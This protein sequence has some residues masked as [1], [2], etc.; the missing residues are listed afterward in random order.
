MK[1]ADFLPNVLTARGAPMGRHSYGIAENCEP[2]SVRLFR[3][4]LDSGGYDRGGAY[5]G[6]GEPLYMAT[7]GGEYRAFTRAASR[8]Y[9]MA[10]LD[11]APER[12]RVLPRLPG[13]RYQI[14][15]EYI[16]KDSC[17]WVFRVFEVSKNPSERFAGGAYIFMGD[18]AS[19]YEA[20]EAALLHYQWKN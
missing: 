5:W 19:R 16:G 20:Y 6:L 10:A 2:R 7:D 15:R 14:G 8:F 12:L 13:N 3:V 4:P 17:R 1:T 18:Y 11:I 9:A